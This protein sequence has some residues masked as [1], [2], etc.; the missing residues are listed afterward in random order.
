MCSETKMFQ[1][2]TWALS[3][4][5]L[6]SMGLWPVISMGGVVYEPPK[7][8]PV[9]MVEGKQFIQYTSSFTSFLIAYTF[10]LNSCTE[11]HGSYV[12]RP[13]AGLSLVAWTGTKLCRCIAKWY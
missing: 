2:S 9:M 6:K 10:F 7:N 1:N 13:A 12:L 8:I 4:L 3:L 5:P 11:N